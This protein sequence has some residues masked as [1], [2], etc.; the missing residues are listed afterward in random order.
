MAI[1]FLGHTKFR[2]RMATAVIKQ[3]E[4]DMQTRPASPKTGALPRH[5][6]SPVNLLQRGNS[7]PFD[8]YQITI[9]AWAN[10][11]L[12]FGNKFLIPALFQLGA[13]GRHCPV[14][15]TWNAGK[16]LSDESTALGLMIYNAT[17]MAL[18]SKDAN[19]A[20]R[21][22]VFK[23]KA[24]ELLRVR[25]R[26]VERGCIDMDTQEMVFRLFRAE[27][28]GR[29]PTAALVH[30]NMLR[31]ILQQRSSRGTID[32]GFLI[33][34]IYHDNHRAA[35]SMVRP[36][37]DHEEFIPKAF[38]AAWTRLPLKL[39]QED[40]DGDDSSELDA[41]VMSPALRNVLSETRPHCRLFT[42][43]AQDQQTSATGSAWFWFISKQQIF[44]GRL[45]N[46]YLD[47]EAADDHDRVDL[48]YKITHQLQ[49]CICLATL[50]TVRLPSDNPMISGR[51]L[52]ESG[53]KILE[54]LTAGLRNVE[55][56]LSYDSCL[57][58]LTTTFDNALLWAYYVGALAG[59]RWQ[60][61]KTSDQFYESRLSLKIHEMGITSWSEMTSVFYKFLYSEVYC[62][63]CH[64]E[65]WFEMIKLAIL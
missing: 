10:R 14:A 58:L 9:D 36:V 1:R 11:F 54:R 55:A 42:L 57:F 15:R 63:P 5:I 50:F 3:G 32:L 20:R 7:D 34:C 29:N 4:V 65:Q 53:S 61:Y 21:S 23:I 39:P 52:Y 8:S 41:S 16:D 19:V 28:L 60:A 64:P 51:P 22:L 18:I 47:L 59:H 12:D 26:Y 24:L 6:A 44:Q 27:I 33:L 2:S 43:M 40:E 37:F 35:A 49:V 45:M 56:Y 31:I 62:A 48:Q 13:W 17:A 46:L 30:G 25:L 38:A